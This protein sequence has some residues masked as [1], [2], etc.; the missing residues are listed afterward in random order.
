MTKL[1]ETMF[2]AAALMASTQAVPRVLAQQQA[3]QAE[4]LRIVPTDSLFDRYTVE[5][6]WGQLPSSQP[7]GGVTTGVAVDG[8][9]TVVVLVRTAPYFRVFTR[10]GRF[11]KA[12]GDAGAFG[13]PHSVHF[14]P[15]GGIW[16]SD[17]NRHV[18]YKFSADGKLL[19][20]L[21]TGARGDNT[22]RDAFTRPA[23]LTI[24]K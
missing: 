24:A 4:P 23:G 15:D 5:P 7:W 18:V 17:P 6:K 11:V 3:P 16:A 20:T 19:M 2:V 8:K 14:G 1:V 12:W 10:D 22:S 13:Q 21:G 9:G